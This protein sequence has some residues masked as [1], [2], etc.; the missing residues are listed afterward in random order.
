MAYLPLI[1]LYFLAFDTSCNAALTQLVL[2]AMG[3]PKHICSLVPP[4]QPISLIYERRDLLR[5]RLGHFRTL[6]L[7]QRSSTAVFTP[8]DDT[9]RHFTFWAFASSGIQ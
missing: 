4:C 6:Y 8:A 2:V 5:L 1:P 9:G 3:L 7:N